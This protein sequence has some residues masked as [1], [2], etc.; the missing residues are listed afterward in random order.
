MRYK[1][2]ESF[3]YT[4]EPS[5]S[6]TFHINTLNEQEVQIAEGELS[7]LNLSP[8]GIRIKSKY[9]LPDPTSYS[10]LLEVRFTLEDQPLCLKGSVQWMKPVAGEYQY[11]LELLLTDKEKNDVIDELKHFALNQRSLN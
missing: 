2:D 10:I 8:G 7:I 1:R 4:F 11:G 9:K 6:G 3:R 5:I